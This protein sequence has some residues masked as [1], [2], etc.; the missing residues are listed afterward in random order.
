MIKFKKIL[1][2]VLAGAMLSCMLV[3]PSYAA[4]GSDDL[5]AS[6]TELDESQLEESTNNGKL[7]ITK[8]LY[9]QK[10]C[11][12]PEGTTFEFK[13]TPVE[14]EN[15]IRNGNSVEKGIALEED[16]V[17]ITFN[18]DSK[19]TSV[20]NKL[21][22]IVLTADFDLSSIKFTN[23]N[24]T[25]YAYKVEE[26]QD[27]NLK[28]YI[29]YGRA[30]SQTSYDDVEILVDNTQ[31][32]VSVKAYGTELGDT[33]KKYPIIF[34]NDC[35][36][37]SI[38][39]SKDLAGTAVKSEDYDIEF[40]FTIEIPVA[41]DEYKDDYGIEGTLTLK[42][43]AVFDAYI[44]DNE[45]G[46]TLNPDDPI[47]V[48]V[49][50]TEFTLKAGQSLSI[51]GVPVGM[52]Y[53]VEEV[54]ETDDEDFTAKLK[55]FTSSIYAQYMEDGEAKYLTD[56]GTGE[57]YVGKTISTDNVVDYTNTKDLAADEG[58]KYDIAPYA[59]IC[60]VVLAGAVVLFIRKRR[61]VK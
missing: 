45:T 12:V 31:S 21:D 33:D 37:T 5:N 22:K 53:S 50:T 14:P 41:G 56:L 58:I 51:P 7:T 39:I 55:E 11:V 15:V 17:Y 24:P 60:L 48:S 3:F 20:N 30:N 57:K 59:V 34:Q 29:K 1:S 44:I 25:Y 52:V 4:T 49:G 13:M 36:T 6:T 54:K 32:I 18:A 38:T 42:D 16:T 28:S 9:I 8:E 47:E 61:S 43:G 2:A 35:I 23:T 19:K 40:P 46:E 26:V 27:N 10:G